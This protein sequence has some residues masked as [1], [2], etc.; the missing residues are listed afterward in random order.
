MKDTFVSIINLVL[1]VLMIGLIMHAQVGEC[2]L[3]ATIVFF[4]M[5]FN[6]IRAIIKDLGRMA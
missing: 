3:E 4:A 1:M 2:R 5:M 6:C